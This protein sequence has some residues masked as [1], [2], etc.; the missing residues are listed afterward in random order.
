MFSMLP[1]ESI[2]ELDLIRFNDED[3]TNGFSEA[4]SEYNE[5]VSSSLSS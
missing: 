2:G 4:F 5:E 3:D 1:V